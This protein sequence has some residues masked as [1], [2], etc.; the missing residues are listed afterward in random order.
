MEIP[1]GAVSGYPQGPRSNE[2]GVSFAP[3]LESSFDGPRR[4]QHEGIGRAVQILSL[5]MPRFLGA[6]GLAPGALLNASGAGG[7]DPYLGA[8]MQTLMRTLAPEG[9]SS[10]FGP[11]GGLDSG[12]GF[13]SGSAAGSRPADPR[14]HTIETPG[15]GYGFGGFDDEPPGDGPSMIPQVGLP[16]GARRA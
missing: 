2:L 8:V 4:G 14:I 11:G 16:R 5:R 6:R 9:A 13:G 15:G 3:T 12:G 10:A 7:M 1:G